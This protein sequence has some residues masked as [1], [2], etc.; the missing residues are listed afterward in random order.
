MTDKVAWELEQE[1]RATN[2]SDWE[3]L[4]SMVKK[5]CAR[6]RY[7]FAV[8]IAE[9]EVTS[10]CPDCAPSQARKRSNNSKT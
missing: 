1:A 2:A 6:C 5:R 10:T 4:P 3:P 9:A 7:F 8:P